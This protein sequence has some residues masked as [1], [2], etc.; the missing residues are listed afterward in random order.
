MN[1]I[2][3]VGDLKKALSVYND[4]LPLQVKDTE[5]NKFLLNNDTLLAHVSAG[6]Y[7]H[8]EICVVRS[9]LK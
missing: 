4:D 3:T 6:D 9:M 7:E 1:M 5:G 8:F 2:N